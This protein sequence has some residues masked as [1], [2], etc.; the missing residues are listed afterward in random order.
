MINI[1]QNLVKKLQTL[2]QILQSEMKERQQLTMF[3]SQTNIAER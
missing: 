2:T 1:H 3:D